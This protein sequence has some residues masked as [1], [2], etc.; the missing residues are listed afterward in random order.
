MDETRSLGF[1]DNLTH[2]SP[3]HTKNGEKIR[4][5]I[6]IWEDVERLVSETEIPGCYG[7]VI[8]PPRVVRRRDR[9]RLP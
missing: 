9:V 4:G 2:T 6:S 1:T 5:F 7:R 3:D 8:Q